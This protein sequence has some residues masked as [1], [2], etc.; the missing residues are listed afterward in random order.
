[1]KDNKGLSKNQSSFS[2]SNQTQQ[3]LQQQLQ[4]QKSPNPNDYKHLKES[5]SI[6][7][8][9]IFSKSSLFK[10]EID[11][12]EKNKKGAKENKDT[13]PSFHKS[14]T[15]IIKNDYSLS[16]STGE[17]S[18]LIRVIGRFRPLN[19]VEEVKYVLKYVGIK[20]ERCWAIMCKVY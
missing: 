19:S 10:I 9:G 14:E 11:K 12:K 2:K 1:M 5:Q 17:K 3:Q 8:P 7:S 13:P 18:T 15:V 20:Q 4:Q 6:A 16:T